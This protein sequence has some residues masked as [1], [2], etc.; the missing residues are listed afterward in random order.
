MNA[1]WERSSP[2]LG[3]ILCSTGGS[4]CQGHTGQRWSSRDSDLHHRTRLA[5]YQGRVSQGKETTAGGGIVPLWGR[6]P[7]AGPRANA[8]PP[9]T[10]RDWVS[11]SNTLRPRSTATAPARSTPTPSTRR[12]TTITGR[13]ASCGYSAGH[14]QK[15]RFAARAAVLRALDR[16]RRH[17]CFCET[18]PAVSRSGGCLVALPRPQSQDQQRVVAATPRLFQV[19]VVS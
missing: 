17:W 10:R 1:L 12:S 18:A 8:E 13:P 7:N 6:R 9:T 4:G 15:E 5:P 14:G 3:Q 19:E 11:S 2:S 16:G